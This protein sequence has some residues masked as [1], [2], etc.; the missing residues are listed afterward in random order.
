MNGFLLI[1]MF[2]WG[3][4]FGSFYNVV[5]YRIPLGLN[6]TKGR[7]FCPVCNHLLSVGDLIPLLSFLFLKRR[8][9][10]CK[11]KISWRYPL[12]ELFTGGLF[13]VGYWKFSLSFSLVQV[14][15]FWSMLLIVAVIDFEQLY[16][17]DAVLLFFSLIQFLF[18]LILNRDIKGA[19]LGA[20][21][22]GAIYFVIYLISKAYYKREVFGLG[23]VLLMAS[24]GLFV[25]REYIVLTSFLPFYISIFILAGM[26]L[27]G[28]KV[29][30]QSELPFGPFMCIGGW[31][32]SMYGYEIKLMLLQ[33][34]SRM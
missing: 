5:I 23:D 7:S 28:K 19:L 31:L 34:A 29:A 4:C 20:L 24:I 8:C 18:I 13:A 14:L 21:I 26:R 2:V 25:G 17:Y 30:M 1:F 33:L 10:Y 12:I 22:G 15:I 9:R 32:M 11:G 6:I 16:I 3:L 27:A